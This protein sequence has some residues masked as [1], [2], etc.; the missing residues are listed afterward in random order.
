MSS[1]FNNFST[2]FGDRLTNGNL[3]KAYAAISLKVLKGLG[4]EY[5]EFAERVK[6]VE[7]PP[8]AF[9]EQFAG[10]YIC[11]VKWGGETGTWNEGLENL[12][13]SPQGEVQL[14]SRSGLAVIENFQIII[15]RRRNG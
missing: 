13:I 9:F 5:A 7:D 10:N 12:L 14:R 15:W 4:G 3:A 8:E 11:A 1:D 6:P 2:F